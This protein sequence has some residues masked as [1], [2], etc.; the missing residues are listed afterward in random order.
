MGIEAPE[1]DLEMTAAVVRVSWGYEWRWDC[2]DSL[3]IAA[4]TPSWAI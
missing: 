4:M 2:G 3:G 1:E